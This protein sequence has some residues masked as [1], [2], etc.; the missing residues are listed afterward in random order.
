VTDAGMKKDYEK[1][2]KALTRAEVK[3]KIKECFN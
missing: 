1:H 3:E 2:G